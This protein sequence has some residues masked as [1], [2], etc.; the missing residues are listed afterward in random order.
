MTIPGADTNTPPDSGGA[1]LAVQHLVQLGHTDIVH[2]DGAANISSRARSHGYEKAMRS[3]GLE[4]RTLRGGDDEAD[5]EAA[6][7][8]LVETD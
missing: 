7:V 8:D 1:A 6:I 5:A 2:I 4:P 3:L